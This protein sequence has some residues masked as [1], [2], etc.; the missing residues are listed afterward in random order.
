M[1]HLSSERLAAIAAESPDA[2]ELAHLASCDQCAR[3]RAAHQ[4]I[5]E[6]A[7]AESAM[8]AA[9]LTRWETLAPALAAHGLIS[10][11]SASHHAGRLHNGWLQAAA[12]LL[13]VA[14]GVAAGRYSAGAAIVPLDQTPSPAAPA[15]AMM[16]DSV[17]HFSSIEEARAAQNQSQTIYQTATAYLA[18]RDTSNQIVGSPSDMRRRLAALDQVSQTMGA[19]L[20]DAPYDPVLNGYYL[21]TL[22][23][24]EATLRQLNTALPVGVRITSY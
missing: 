1:S 10:P 23:Q 19:A 16:S 11:G 5:L 12:A 17:P 18:Q 8:I 22:G 13:L 15:V 3:E 6:L 9:P 14:G 20:E 24:R 7:S 2:A 4:R 21:T